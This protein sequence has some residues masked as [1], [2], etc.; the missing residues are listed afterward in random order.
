MTF[1]EQNRWKY[2][3]KSW[4]AVAYSVQF[5]RA[6]HGTVSFLNFISYVDLSSSPL[7]NPYLF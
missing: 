7:S 5:Y 3:D 4:E 6:H 1:P 2:S